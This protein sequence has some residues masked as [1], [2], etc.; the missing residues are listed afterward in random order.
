MMKELLILTTT[1]VVCLSLAGE[2]MA[3]MKFFD[4]EAKMSLDGRRLVV[5]G[6][7]D[8]VP[9][10]GEVTVSISALQNGSLAVARG[11]SAQQACTEGSD[12]F[13]AEL[14]VREGRPPFTA[15]PVQACALAT[16]RNGDKLANVDQ[17]CSFVQVVV[18]PAM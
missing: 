17:W 18:D 6:I 14:T 3:L 13:T 5:T 16:M 11:A 2:A 15:G 7:T 12:P 9:A 4:P 10:D 8:C 1:A